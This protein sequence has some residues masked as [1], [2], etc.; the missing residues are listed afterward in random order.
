[1]VRQ[2]LARHFNLSRQVFFLSLGAEH[3]VRGD[4]RGAMRSGIRWGAAGV[5]LSLSSLVWSQS[6]PPAK[7]P[8]DG[9]D[10]SSENSIVKVPKNTIIV[11]GAWS[12]TSDS[13]TPVPE[14]NR[15]SNG[16]FSNPYFGIRYNLPAGFSK[17]YDGPPPSESGRY[18]L[19]Q[20]R[21]GD[22]KQQTSRGSILITADDLFFTSLPVDNALKFVGYVKDHLQADYQQEQPPMATQIAGRPFVFFAYWS[23]VAQLHWYVAAT[24]IRCHAVELVLTSRDTK[25]LTNWLLDVADKM[26]LPAE[27]GP[28]AGAGG[29][30]FP[31]CVKD[32]AEKGNVLAR[33]DPVFPEPRGNSVPVRII[34]D[35][36][37]KVKHI[38]LLSA[39]PEQAKAITDALFEWRFKPYFENGQPVEVETGIVF[40]GGSRPAASTAAS[41]SRE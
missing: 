29:G 37:G 30:R 17:N 41:A 32:Y 16:V 27:A 8:V 20:I 22:Q 4:L 23:P 31:V 18:V 14:G 3:V 36:E 28:T 10:L 40:G 25:L 7:P 24:E 9:G 13:V 34:I 2:F 35:K 38:H 19:A 6:S 26:A 33:V 15:L 39:F 5:L 21:M 1:M 12:S 11:K